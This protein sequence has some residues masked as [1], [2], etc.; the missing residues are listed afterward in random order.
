MDPNTPKQ[1]SN[2]LNDLQISVQ[3]LNKNNMNA[4]LEKYY[5]LVNIIKANCQIR[6]GNE[7]ITKT[8]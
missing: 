6:V 5:L 7:A 2:A 4:N 1:T 3:N 8:E